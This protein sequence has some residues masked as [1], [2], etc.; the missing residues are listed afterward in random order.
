MLAVQMSVDLFGA[1]VRMLATR[2]RDR[3]EPASRRTTW[4]SFGRS[5][6]ISE[7]WAALSSESLQPFEAGFLTDAK[8]PT[9]LSHRLKTTQSDLHEALTRLQQRTSFPRHSRGKLRR[10]LQDPHPCPCSPPSPM[11]WP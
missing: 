5:R 2:L 9:Q 3:L 7:S 6:P 4:R 11:S 1:P 10:K 8:V